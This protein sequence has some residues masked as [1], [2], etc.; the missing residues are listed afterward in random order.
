VVGSIDMFLRPRG[1]KMCLW[2]YVLRVRPETRSMMIPA[3]SIPT[4]GVLVFCLKIGRREKRT[5][6][7][8]PTFSRLL[9]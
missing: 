5:Y 8:L 3:Q 4:Y 1:S 9:N 2:K 7:V 6:T